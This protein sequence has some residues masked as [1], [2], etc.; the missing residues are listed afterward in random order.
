[1]TQRRIDVGAADRFEGYV[2]AISAAGDDCFEIIGW[3]HDLAEPL[4]P[5]DV[6]V[7]SADRILAKL[8][9]NRFRE[10]LRAAGYGYGQ[11]GFHSVIPTEGLDLGS[12]SVVIAATGVPVGPPRR[13]SHPR[14]RKR[15]SRTSARCRMMNTDLM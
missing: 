8:T 5:V 10:D 6:E 4:A 14:Q 12:L 9:A 2:D 11:H 3:A 15:L 1:L 13:K 7:V